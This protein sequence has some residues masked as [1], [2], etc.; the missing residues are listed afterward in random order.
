MRVPVPLINPIENA[1][2]VGTPVLQASFQA[3][4]VS[5]SPDFLGIGW[6]DGGNFVGILDPSLE[7]VQGAVFFESI[8]RPAGIWKT[9]GKKVFIGKD[10]LMLEVMNRKNRSDF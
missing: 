6:A 10:A 5:R 7:Q 4:S 1:N 3:A 8:D 9:G 2:Q